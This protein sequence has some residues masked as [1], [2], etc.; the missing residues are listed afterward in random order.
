[1]SEDLRWPLDQPI[2][3]AYYAGHEKDSPPRNAPHAF[4]RIRHYAAKLSAACGLRIDWWNGPPHE[5]EIRYVFSQY[6]N[7]SLIGRKDCLAYPEDPCLFFGASGTMDAGA[8]P[9]DMWSEWVTHE[10]LHC[11]GFGH[12]QQHDRLPG[13]GWDWSE[14]A[15]KVTGFIWDRQG[16]RFDDEPDP[17]SVMAYHADAS[18]TDPPGHWIARP[19]RWLSPTDLRRLQSIYPTQLEQYIRRLYRL[20]LLRDPDAAGLAHWL[21]VEDRRKIAHGILTSSEATTKAA[22]CMY[23]LILGRPA[24]AGE[25][26]WWVATHGADRLAIASGIMASDEFYNRKG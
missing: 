2:R 16:F 14:R 21:A 12:E 6:G 17:T 4:D 5:A 9:D 13:P 18:Y 10:L 24:R 8:I 11:L 22:R 7:G 15:R 25:A 1:M 3:L 26:E 19:S 23:Q 20:L